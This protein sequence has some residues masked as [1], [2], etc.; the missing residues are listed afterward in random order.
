M[1]LEVVAL[2]KKC[3]ESSLRVVALE[4]DGGPIEFIVLNTSHRWSRWVSKGSHWPKYVSESSLRVVS[5]EKVG[6][7]VEFNV[8]NIFHRGS[9]WV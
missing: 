9:R 2:T 6:C 1:G 5:L 3:T 8:L 7:R 4:K